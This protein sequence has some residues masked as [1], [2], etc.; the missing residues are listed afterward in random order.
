MLVLSNSINRRMKGMLSIEGLR[1]HLHLH[2]L[3]LNQDRSHQTSSSSLQW[4]AIGMTSCSTSSYRSST[5]WSIKVSIDFLLGLKSGTELRDPIFEGKLC[6]VLDLDFALLST[7]KLSELDSDSD[8]LLRNCVKDETLL[9]LFAKSFHFIEPLQ[10][11]VKLRPG[12]NKFL[13]IA[14]NAFRLHG[15]TTRSREETE[16]I[17]KLIDP[18]GCFFGKGIIYQERAPGESIFKKVN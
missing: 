5:K 16:M 7:T 11:W 4:T 10:I 14:R 17:L 2:R 12:L 15:H 1:F 9:P 13:R 8:A 6:L 3:C 18:D